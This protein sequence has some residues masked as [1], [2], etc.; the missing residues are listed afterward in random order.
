MLNE[1]AWRVEF[2]PRVLFYLPLGYNYSP[3]TVHIPG[4]M[5]QFSDPQLNSRC[6]YPL[7]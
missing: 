4:T 3:Y 7:L 6:Y 5:S 1:I 2:S